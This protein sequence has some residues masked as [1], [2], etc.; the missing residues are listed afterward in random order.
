MLKITQL[1]LSSDKIVL[2]ID[3]SSIRPPKKIFLDTYNLSDLL[4]D[5]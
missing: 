1:G 3:S 4:Y 2:K 5:T